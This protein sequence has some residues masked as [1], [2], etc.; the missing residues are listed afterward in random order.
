MDWNGLHTGLA[1]SY[2]AAL[3][4]IGFLAGRRRQDSSQFLNATGAF[5]LWVCILAAIAANCGSLDVIAMMALGAQYGMLACHFYWIGAIPALLILAFWLLP[6]Y[7]RERYPSVLDFI[8]AHY[9][10]KTRA[11]VALGMASMMLLLAGVC[12][13]ATAQVAATF[14]GWSFM[15][16]VLMAAAGVL[17]YTA[18]GGLRATVY[19]E[20]LHFAVV[21]LA[22]VPLGYFVLRDF[23]GLQPLLSSIPPGRF[24][25]WHELPWLG[26]H[27]VMDRF[28]LILGL[29]IV[30]SFG[31][32]STDF[33]V[34]Q[35]ALAVRR[36]QDVQY[37]P[38][39]LAVAKLIFAMLIVVPG[40]VAPIVLNNKGGND[41]NGT[42]PSMMLHYYDPFWVVIGVLGLAASLVATFANNVSGFSAAWMQGF[43][44]P[45]VYA[46]GTESHYLWMS[47][48][49]NVAAVLLSIGAAHFAL[50]YH[51]IM[52]YMQMIF[53]AF[54]GPLLALVLLAA[55]APGSA[56]GGGLIGF[57]VGLASA[58]LHQMLVH[59][60][61][62]QYGSAM[63]ANFYAATLSMSMAVLGTLIS[64][65][66]ARWAGTDAEQASWPVRVS[67][68]FS[69][70]VALIA[71][72]ILVVC[73]LFN[74]IF[75]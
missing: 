24:H 46:N 3:L 59:A 73:V 22:I 6:T 17:F 69:L 11:A 21:L 16:G 44:R 72:A 57:T 32:W 60:G 62:L 27:A 51:S 2:V 56:A 5:P 33:V 8:G 48:A 28:G 68:Q 54:N 13:C 53:S 65:R 63:S 41:W 43:Y 40:V 42:L 9:G 45:W 19:T 52:E 36:A 1:V 37:V 71:S 66:L 35:R 64:A 34:M 15:N 26:P 12:L 49:T 67:V 58:V 39:A 10:A 61:V 31:Y 75:H 4:L 70:P 30:L 55:I 38:L 29:G 18:M 50:A 25:A 7:A 20:L 14:L 47:R 74:A 23:G